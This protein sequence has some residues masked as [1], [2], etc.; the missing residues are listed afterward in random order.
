MSW[1]FTSFALFKICE[2]IIG[3]L[4][5]RNLHPNDSTYYITNISIIRMKKK[6]KDT[7]VIINYKN[8]ELE[9]HNNSFYPAPGNSSLKKGEWI[10]WNLNF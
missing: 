7:I 8:V 9:I 1:K 10:K 3:T 6:D 5:T 2:R 4:T